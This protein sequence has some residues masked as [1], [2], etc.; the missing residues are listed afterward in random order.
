MLP[1]FILG[2]LLAGA[3][4]LTYAVIFVGRRERTLPPGPKTL[5]IIGNLHQIPTKGSY[6]TFTKWA[7]QYGG[8]FSLKLGPATAIVLTDRKYVKQLIDKKSSIY[9]DRPH[10][11]VSHNLITGGDHVLIAHYGKVWQRY[12]KLIHQFFM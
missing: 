12:R 8:I 1:Y 6:L 11:Y 3:A 7:K 2:P 5:P 9:S 10:S 4:L